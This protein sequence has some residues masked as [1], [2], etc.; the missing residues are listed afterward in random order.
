MIPKKIHYIW[1]GGKTKPSLAIA[2]IN[3]WK[4]TL[5]DYEIIEWNEENL[6]LQKLCKESRFL[7]ACVRLKLWAFA[8]DW[9]RLYILY[10]EGGIYLD[11]DVEVLKSYNELLANI[12]FIGLEKDNYI[13]TGVI[14]A[15]KDNQTIKKL[16]DFYENEIWNVDFI[17]NPI[18][19]RYLY[20]RNPDIF[21][22]CKI[23]PRDYF[24]PYSP[25][26]ECRGVVE[27]SNTFSI[28]WYSG[29]WNLSRKGYVFM[30]TKH[31]ANPLKHCVQVIRKSIGYSLKR[32]NKLR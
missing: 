28:H 24:S 3:S 23:Y 29:N 4:R 30:N 5:P 9:L 14:G 22:N 15:E 17:N 21:V 26:Q 7:D 27:T 1:L 2:C 12:M 16:L 8:S 6:N 18:I 13:G 19:F 10:K 31:I 32:N 11:T 20:D 25:G